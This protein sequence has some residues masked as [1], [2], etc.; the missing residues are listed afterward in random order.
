MQQPTTDK[1]KKSTRTTIESA[2]RV[3][4]TTQ[5]LIWIFNGIDKSYR[6]KHR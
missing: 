6:I 4:I 1:N 3:G 2:V 5:L